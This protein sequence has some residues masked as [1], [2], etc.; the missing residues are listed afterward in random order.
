MMKVFMF[1]MYHSGRGNTTID[2]GIVVATTKEEALGL[3][4]ERY[5]NMS[6]TNFDITLIDTKDIQVI[7]MSHEYSEE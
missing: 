4:L 1:D 2:N 3:L 7:T 5:T 6:A